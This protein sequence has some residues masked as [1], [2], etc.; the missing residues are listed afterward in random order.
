[1]SGKYS[2]RLAAPQETEKSW[3]NPSGAGNKVSRSALWAAGSRLFHQHTEGSQTTDGLMPC[4]V[5]V[6]AA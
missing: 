6:L 5:T 1:M 3:S 4:P 2:R